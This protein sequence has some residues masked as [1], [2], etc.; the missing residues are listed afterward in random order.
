MCGIAGLVHWGRRDRAELAAVV[1]RMDAVVAPRGPD[2]HGLEILESAG[3][4][5]AVFAHRRLAIL[6]RSDA[7]LQ[8]MGDATGRVWITFNGEIY[9]YRDLAAGV[10]ADGA[11]LRSS[12]DTEV[13][14]EMLAREGAL[15]V[16]RLRG[17][18]AFAAIDRSTGA[19]TLARDRFGIKPLVWCRPSADTVL[20]ASTPQALAASGLFRLEPA[21]GRRGEFLARGSIGAD[22]SF[23]SGVQVV[24]PAR[25]MTFDLSGERA[26]PYWSLEA[27]LSTTAESASLESAA[28]ACRAAIIDSVAAHLV[29]DVPVAVFLSGG[30]DS[31]AIAAAARQAGGRDLRTITVTMPGSAL[32]ESVVAA[33][34]AARLG[35]THSEV[36]LG[37]VDRDAALDA[38]FAAMAQPTV[39]GFNTFL[40]AR[41]A[42]DAGVQV[43][44]SGM[45]GDEL[46]GGYPSF[47]EVPRLHALLSRWSSGVRAGGAALRRWP[48]SRVAK[49]TS[50]AHAPSDSLSDVWRAYRGVWPAAE[51]QA[52]TGEQLDPSPDISGAS[53]FDVIR[54]LE[55]RQFLER[56]LLP[57][58]DAF[59]MCRALEL[60]V[61]FVDHVMLEAVAYAGR[62]RRGRYRTWKAALFHQWPDWLP[63]ARPGR[64]KQ[65]FILPMDT[66]L[67]QALQSSAPQVWRDVAER[68]RRPEYAVAVSDFLARRTHWTR[69]WSLYVLDRMTDNRS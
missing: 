67:R 54:Q 30:L 7:G 16:E 27:V 58:A 44:L 6:D 63:E 55:W 9:N 65:G 37:E 34:T 2:G 22:R 68:L 25:V 26:V 11:T 28:E 10:V 23:W 35:A 66:W 40:V 33:A 59:T 50:M 39:D 32:D 20:F 13:L 62:W 47:V 57:D 14:V 45:G 21:A 5:V 43:V 64:R 18:F 56:Q 42:R 61:P 36:S 29:S 60:R 41:A 4:S 31:S 51:A 53:P 24:P 17:M 52:I 49:L 46:F 48:S 12:S 19:L 3:D 8:P 15:G 38:F 1:E 69:L